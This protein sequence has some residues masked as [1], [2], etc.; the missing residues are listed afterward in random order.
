VIGLTQP[1]ITQRGDQVEVCLRW[2][3]L[4]STPTDYTVFLHLLDSTGKQIG[5][6][7]SQPK[8]GQ[9]PTGVWSPGEVIDDCVTL[10][11]PNL[12][13]TG[14]KI[15]LGLYDGITGQRLPLTDAKGNRL[16]DDTLVVSATNP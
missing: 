7:D 2:I 9:Y 1:K 3:S 6:G 11:A 10:S 5:Q 12:P 14:W 15:P 13:S 4:A 8:A 16:A